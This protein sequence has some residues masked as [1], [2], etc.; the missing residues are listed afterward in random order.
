MRNALILSLVMMLAMTQACMAKSYDYDMIGTNI[1]LY[2]NGTAL[3][4]QERAY[5]FDGSFSFAYLDIFKSGASDVSFISIVDLD[6]NQ[7]VAYELEEDSSHAKATWYYSAS[8]EVKRFLI[9]YRIDGAV[10]R[11]QDVAEFYW[12]VIED[13]HEP[14]ESLDAKLFLPSPSPELFKIFVHSS[15]DPGTLEFSDDFSSASISMEGIPRNT[16]VEFR[17]LADPSIF[18]GVPMTEQDTYQI[19]IDQESDNFALNG[20]VSSLYPYFILI[21]LPFI[22]L[23]VFYLR[24]GREP[25]VDYELNYEQEPPRDIPP[26]ALSSMYGTD[27]VNSS[28]GFLAT[29]FDLARRGFLD[30]R[31]EKKE[32]SFL[33]DKTEQYFSITKKGMNEI[34]SGSLHSF[35]KDVL[36]LLLEVGDGKEFSASDMVKWN[37]KNSYQLPK[38]IGKISSD[39]RSWLEGEC[40]KLYEEGSKKSSKIFVLS[41][42]AYIIAFIIL[43]IT[44]ILWIGLAIAALFAAFIAMIVGSFAIRK[45]TPEYALE[46]KKWKAFKRYITDFSAM[47]DAPATMLHIWD[48]YLVYAVVLGVARQLLKNLSALSAER[49]I[50]VA[51]VAWYHPSGLKTGGMMTPQAFDAFSSNM[52][53]MVTALSA[54]SSVGGGFSGGGGGGGGGGSSGAG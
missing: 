35:E 37:M 53:N 12:K 44:G 52:S 14:I 51:A 22:I 47:K 21:A 24:C 40:F 33:P 36:K 39:A 28:K 7:E 10:K 43:G 9:T 25:K 1:S 11:Y 48:R 26:M 15:A 46:M 54:S 20:V 3:V 4:M 34:K 6:T 18:A 49:N 2:E 17:V 45:S 31:E 5:D 29:V 8:D 19:I 13:D 32:R 50:P 16:F 23:L 42:T 27:T 30:I 38:R 41:M